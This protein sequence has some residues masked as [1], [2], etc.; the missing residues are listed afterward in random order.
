MAEIHSFLV[1]NGVNPS[2]FDAFICNSGADLYYSSSHSE[3]N[4][5][6]SDLYYHSHIEYRWGG[7]GLRK[8][9]AKWASSIIDKK[10]A[11]KN[12]EHV[13]TEDE[14]IS[15]NYCYAFNIHK[16]GLVPPVKEL[17]KLMRIHALFRHCL[18]VY[19]LAEES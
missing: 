16:P 18:F 17:R 7:E 5:F 1:S 13:V 6:V 15:T 4:P 14:E 12:E 8:T 19:L 9:L 11:S 10:A 2:D 3:D